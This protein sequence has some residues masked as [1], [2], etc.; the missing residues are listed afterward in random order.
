MLTYNRPLFI[1]RAVSSVYEQ[2]FQAWELIIVQDGSNPETAGLLKDWI[3][4]DA[5]IRY[6]R[7]GVAGSI[8]VTRVVVRCDVDRVCSRSDHRARSRT[9]R[10]SDVRMPGA[11]V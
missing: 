2:T 6:F 3:A 4:K 10:I 11:C 7:R 5:R 9:L 1:R 8:I